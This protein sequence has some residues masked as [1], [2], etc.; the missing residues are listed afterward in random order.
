MTEEEMEFF[1]IRRGPGRLSK[2]TI[3]H[4]KRAHDLAL[5]GLT[6]EEIAKSFGIDQ[7]TLYDWKNRYPDFAD[8]INEG[9]EPADAK[10]VAALF[11]RAMGMAIPDG[12]ETK[13]DDD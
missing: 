6:D 12:T 9:K 2:Y 10:I 8:S 7:S 4:N 13:F 1:G 11:N 5:L 3:E